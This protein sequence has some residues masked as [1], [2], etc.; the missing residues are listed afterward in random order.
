MSRLLA[1]ATGQPR[2]VAACVRTLEKINRVPGGGPAIAAAGGLSS[3]LAIV[4]APA[5][6]YAEAVDPTFRLLDRMCRV[7]ESMEAL[8]KADG[9]QVCVSVVGGVAASRD[10]A[11]A[12]DAAGA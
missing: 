6:M 7:A 1:A 11:R 9:M 8:R 12:G 10:A 4:Q 2:I 3:L 5:E